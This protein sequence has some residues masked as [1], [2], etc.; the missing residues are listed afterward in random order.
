[1]VGSLI[2]WVKSYFTWVNL[3]LSFLSFIWIILDMLQSVRESV[4]YKSS[5]RSSFN[6]VGSHLTTP[7]PFGSTP[8]NLGQVPK[9]LDYVLSH[10]KLSVNVGVQVVDGLPPKVNCITYHNNQFTCAP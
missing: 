9:C 4:I 5:D 8:C 7:L 3:F 2:V 10:S 6:K 1:M